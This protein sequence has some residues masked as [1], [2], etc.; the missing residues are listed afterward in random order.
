MNLLSPFGWLHGRA[1]NVRNSLYDRGTFASHSL[2]AR[3]ISIG[4]ITAGGTGKTP[5][6]ALVSE[7]LA[8]NGEKICILTRGY[9]RQNPKDRI[10]VSDS[11]KVLVDSKTG[12]DEPVE[13]AHKLI[14]KAVIVADANRVS[15]AKWA[16]EKFGVTAF[17]LDDGFQHRRAKRDL[18]IV[19]IDAT[20]PFGGGEVLPA[21]RLREPLA[22]LRRADSIVITR[23]NFAEEIENLK[24]QISNLNPAAAIFLSENH[25]AR[26]RTLEEF[27]AKTQSSQ[28]DAKQKRAFAFCALGN[29]NNF[30]EQLKREDFDLAGTETFPD[31]YFYKQTDVDGLE[32]KAGEFEIGAFVTTAK[33]AVKLKDMK[34][35]IPCY[36]V[37]IEPVISD[38]EQFRKLIT[39]S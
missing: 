35:E 12:G 17:V 9:G 33:D 38:A 10:L 27:H 28:R 11:A 19:C 21:G 34:F 24:F 2:G 36:V 32:K 23:S 39:A 22:N 18:D 16:M 5:L 26:L 31:H 6:V 29:P 15:A 7:I 20:N 30:F 37:E 13:L 3:T 4:N 1:A 8:E 14:G 25:I